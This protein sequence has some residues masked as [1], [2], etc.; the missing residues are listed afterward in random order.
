MIEKLKAEMKQVVASFRFFIRVLNGAR[1]VGFIGLRKYR[2]LSLVRVN[3]AV[4][5]RGI[6]F[7]YGFIVTLGGLAITSI[8]NLT[9]LRRH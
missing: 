4:N 8:E 7:P 2:V 3:T 9:D 1:S 5:T 6:Y